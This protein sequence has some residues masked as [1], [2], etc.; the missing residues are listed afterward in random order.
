MEQVAAQA[1]RWSED[2]HPAVLGR[3]V[4]LQ[5]FSTWPGGQLVVADADGQVAGD[6]LGRHGEPA[7]VAAARE[8]LVTPVGGF[9][10]AVIDLQGPAVE[11]AGLSC[12]GRAELLMQRT[13]RVPVELWG[14]VRR[15]EPVALIT[16]TGRDAAG[17]ESVVVG[18]DGHWWGEL[19]G[20]QAGAAR[21]SAPPGVDRAA[22]LLASG[23]TATVHIEDP[24]GDLVISAWVPEPRLVVVGSGDMVV[25]LRS[26]AG[27]LG[28]DVRDTAAVD[29]VK[30]LLAWAGGSAALIVLS[31]DPHIDAPALQAGLGA[32]APYVGAMGSRNTQ[33][34]RL[35]RLREL[36]VPDED[37]DRI[38]RPIGLDL[39]GR[40][41]PDVA[42]AICAEIL[43]AHHGRDARPLRDA[44]GSI[45]GR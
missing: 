20:S 18:A 7:V 13:D 35:Q 17:P 30:E 45:R 23:H 28:W 16:R 11:E 40:G 22:A 42:L 43:A 21:P 33:S 8:L 38:H 26:Q 10:R 9:G 36:G 37:L 1:E 6:V 31:H 24:G 34:R 12:G 25:A 15:R 14:K 44:T 39:G 5:G 2:G 4:D 3:V 41:A 27:L 19:A 32:R 29:D